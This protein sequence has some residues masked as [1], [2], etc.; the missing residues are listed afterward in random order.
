[1]PRTVLSLG[2]ALLGVAALAAPAQAVLVNYTGTI[3]LEFP[4]SVGASA[5]PV[6]LATLSGQVEFL[7]QGTI[8]FQEPP[9]A[10][11]PS[12]ATVTLSGSTFL[13]TLRIDPI[14]LNTGSLIPS[15]SVSPTGFSG[16]VGLSGMLS[17][18][19]TTGLGLANLSVPLAIGSSFSTS[20][21]SATGG[22]SLFLSV[23]FSPWTAGTVSLSSTRDGTTPT[24]VPTAMGSIMPTV[25]GMA[26]LVSPV[27]IFRLGNGDQFRTIPAV[28]RMTLNFVPEP[29]AVLLQG[30][31]LAT[32]L[33]VGI[34]RFRS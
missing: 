23:Y 15:T 3:E 12:A 2:L 30:I 27:S 6:S 25:N 8:V 20:T 10:F 1:M 4:A 32:L 28:G 17:F 21:S 16:T 7:P 18:V 11:S 34:R 26:N 33:L 31:A 19:P 13:S 9:T 29:A 14:V 24:P 5:T 22:Q